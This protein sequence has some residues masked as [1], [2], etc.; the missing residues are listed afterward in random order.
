MHLR[1][2]CVEHGRRNAQRVFISLAPA[3]G[4]LRE[5]EKV[6]PCLNLSIGRRPATPKDP[7]PAVRRRAPQAFAGSGSVRGDDAPRDFCCVPRQKPTPPWTWR[8]DIQMS[9]DILDGRPPH[10]LSASSVFSRKRSEPALPTRSPMA[11]AR[12]EVDTF[13][14][15][16]GRRRRVYR[17]CCKIGARPA[18]CQPARV[19]VS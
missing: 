14:I 18:W 5:C 10:P 16:E 1:P 7:P 3:F 19:L 17:P 8:G 4:L 11:R 13:T 2:T 12:R 6:L 9:P 15:P